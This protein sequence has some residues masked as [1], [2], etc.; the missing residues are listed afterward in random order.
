MAIEDFRNADNLMIEAAFKHMGI[1]IYRHTAPKG[2]KFSDLTAFEKC[3]QLAAERF[4]MDVRIDYR[5]L[6][7]SG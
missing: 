4:G 6:R 2:R 7:A 5:A 1:P 3:V